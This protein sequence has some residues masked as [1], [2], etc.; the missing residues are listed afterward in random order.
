[1]FLDVEGLPDRDFYYLIGVRVEGPNGPNHHAL[2]A[3]SVADQKRIW[4]DSSASF[5]KPI[6]RRC[7]ITAVSK[8]RF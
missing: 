3:D 1:M 8:K 4:E 6:V 2:W 5:R 7:F